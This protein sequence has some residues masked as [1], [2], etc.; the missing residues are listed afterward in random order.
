[1]LDPLFELSRQMIRRI[2][3]PYQ[4]TFPKGKGFRG[5]CNLVTGQRGVGKTTM[6]VQ[7]LVRKFPDHA[8]SRKCLYLPADHFVVSK[9]PLYEVAEVFAN[10]GGKLL[11]V[12]E[13]H[14][15]DGWARD[16]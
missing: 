7:Y 5:R 14:K 10:Q 1:M 9:Q 4:R 13:I 11:C 3:R 16:L 2:V 15:A 12:D 8:A 6:V